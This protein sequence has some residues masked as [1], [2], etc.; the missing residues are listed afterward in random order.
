MP[1][2]LAVP[3]F[4]CRYYNNKVRKAPHVVGHYAAGARLIGLTER[5]M[6]KRFA[7]LS[8]SNKE[9]DSPY[10]Q[11]VVGIFVNKELKPRFGCHMTGKIKL[12]VN[13]ALQEAASLS[14]SLEKEGGC[15]KLQSQSGLLPKVSYCRTHSLQ[16]QC[17]NNHAR[18]TLTNPFLYL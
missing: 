3:L 16:V 11:P 10:A 12:K 1:A 4:L 5:E 13:K 15:S 18:L 17:H 2:I 6:A 8:V 9:A 7:T 14:E